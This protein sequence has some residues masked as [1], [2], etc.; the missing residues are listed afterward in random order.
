MSTVVPRTPLV[1]EMLVSVGATVGAAGALFLHA[2][3]GSASVAATNH[4]LNFTRQNVWV[5]PSSSNERRT[6]TPRAGT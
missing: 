1:G 6:F 2:D 5:A 4:A 3:A